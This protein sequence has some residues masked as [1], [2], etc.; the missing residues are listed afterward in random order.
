MVWVA[1]DRRRAALDEYLWNY[2]KLAFVPHAVWTKNMGDLDDPV[3]LVGEAVNPNH[4]G[5]LVVGDDPPPEAWAA[6]FDEVHDF[7][8]PGDEG[9]ERDQW[10]QAWKENHG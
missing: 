10:W 4:A 1:A 8:A 3:V 6:E 9:A 5:T 7:L 2:E